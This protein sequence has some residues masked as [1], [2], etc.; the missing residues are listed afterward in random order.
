MKPQAVARRY[1]QGFSFRRVLSHVLTVSHDPRAVSLLRSMP[2]AEP[3][4]PTWTRPRPSKL[5][6]NEASAHYLERP[7]ELV[8]ALLC[9]R[10]LFQ[11][12]DYAPRIL[13]GNASSQGTIIPD[14]DAELVHCSLGQG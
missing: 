10:R 9:H 4:M 14:T 8:D 3:T 12:D 1:R 2:I 5:C 6:A 7:L 11:L 13:Q